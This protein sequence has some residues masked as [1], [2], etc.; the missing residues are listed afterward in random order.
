MMDMRVKTEKNNWRKMGSG[1]KDDNLKWR[2][3]IVET[4]E[5]SRSAR[6]D[7]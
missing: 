7:V 5:E 4:L 2:K 6:R 1:R 3:T